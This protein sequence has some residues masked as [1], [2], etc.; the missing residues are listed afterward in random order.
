M[1]TGLSGASVQVNYRRMTTSHVMRMR[2][3]HI[4]GRMQD[5]DGG[6]G[7]KLRW[8]MHVRKTW[9]RRGMEE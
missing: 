3:E 8:K 4:V 5:V 9:P 7:A 6:G 2:K 1:T